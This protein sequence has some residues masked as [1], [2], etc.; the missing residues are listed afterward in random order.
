MIDKESIKWK[1][2]EIEQQDD[3]IRNSIIRKVNQAIGLLHQEILISILH[4]GIDALLL[5]PFSM[6]MGHEFYKPQLDIYIK[7]NA[8]F[9]KFSGSFDNYDTKNLKESSLPALSQSNIK[10]TEF[11]IDENLLNA[12][13]YQMS[14]HKIE[15]GFETLLSNFMSVEFFNNEI[16]RLHEN[17]FKLFE[18]SVVREH[19]ASKVI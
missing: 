18:Y 11:L 13:L 9:V 2:G 19:R 16:S 3:V 12:F 5:N 15:F 14:N 10:T 8:L 17:F 1:I 4:L 6:F 7:N